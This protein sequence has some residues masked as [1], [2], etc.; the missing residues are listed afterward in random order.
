MRSL[1]SVLLIALIGLTVPLGGRALAQGPCGEAATVAAGD[2]LSAIA[3][4]CQSTVAAIVDANPEIANPDLIFPGMT[5]RMPAAGGLPPDTLTHSVLPGEM[6]AAIAERYGTSIEA[7][8]GANPQLAEGAEPEVGQML[9]VPTSAVN[10]RVDIAPLSGTP[11]TPITV[12][13]RGYP[14]DLAVIVGLGRGESEFAVSREHVTDNR[15]NLRTMVT[16]PESAAPG[17]PWVV[18]VQT[19]DLPRVQAESAR[20][21][22]TAGSE[23]MHTVV[24][25]DTLARLALRYGVSVGL[26]LEANPEITDPNV[27]RV[28]Q[29]LNI[30]EVE[31]V[32]V[33]VPFIQ[34]EGGDLGCGDALVRIER[35]VPATASPL[36]VALESLF[37]LRGEDVGG[38]LYNP[39]A[40]SEV[41]VEEARIEGDVATIRLRGALMPGGVCDLPRI[42][43]QLR[44]VA[45]QFEG[46]QTVEVTVNDVPLED[47]LS[48]RG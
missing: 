5:V 45:L 18:V 7:I 34:L 8:R 24:P 31:T 28:G 2:T 44:E 27:I 33:Q 37:S 48:E 41:T 32:T 1:V 3:R 38:E 19:A 22:V 17:D 16:L 47:V 12:Q 23:G 36:E 35:T 15:G 43:A 20:F 4:R 14:A 21:T 30:P 9:L 25:G 39:L 29:V 11:G 46:I 26:L 42:E 13:A 10:P 40:A 6:L